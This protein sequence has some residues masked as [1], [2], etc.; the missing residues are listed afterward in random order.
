M[1][2]ARAAAPLTAPF[3]QTGRV[4]IVTGAG[5]ASG[6]GLATARLL[7]RL[8]AAV[9]LA[10]TT[11]RVHERVAELRREGVTASGHV[12]DLT[13][14]PAARRHPAAR[15]R[16]RLSVLHPAAGGLHTP[17]VGSP[18]W[19]TRVLTPPETLEGR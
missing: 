6:I 14:E 2:E 15:A 10:A 17:S 16:T 19:P 9:V 1:A 13:H 5:S 4:A 3:D 18:G 8:G 12:G 7:G 11:D